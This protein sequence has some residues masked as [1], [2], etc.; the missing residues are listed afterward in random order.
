[1][2]F[3][4]DVKVTT[5]EY[6]RTYYTF[7]LGDIAFEGHQSKEFKF[8]RFVENDLGNGIVSHIFAVFR[9]IVNYDLNFRKYLINNEGIMHGILSRSTKASTMMHDLVTN[10]FLKEEIIVPSIEEQIRIG[11]CFKYIDNLLTLHQRKFYLREI[12]SFMK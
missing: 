1:M 12:C 9:P 3:K 2:Q 10:D 4:P 5:E 11:E 8:G 7:N 6:L